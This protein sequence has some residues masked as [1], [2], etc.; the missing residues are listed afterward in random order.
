MAY[1][2]DA[3]A[4]SYLI[5][6]LDDDY[7]RVRMTAIQTLGRLGIEG[8]T[9]ELIKGLDDEHDRVRAAGV[10]ALGRVGDETALQQL[11]EEVDDAD[12]DWFSRVD[13]AISSIEK[14]H[15]N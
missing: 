15:H 5:D 10:I 1:L 13:R 4:A 6:A 14:R 3:A 12:D 11:I 2:G 9:P 7:W 8:I